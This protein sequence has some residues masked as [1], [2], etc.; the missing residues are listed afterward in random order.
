ME[1]SLVLL[2]PSVTKKYSEI[3]TSLK[4]HGFAI[5]DVCPERVNYQSQRFRLTHEQ[6]TDFF[7]DRI[8]E[9]QFDEILEEVCGGDVI[10]LIVAKMDV[11]KE[12]GELLRGIESLR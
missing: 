12:L 7:Q 11:Y 6:A 3:S 10:S 5:K 2:K 8:D 9:S 4:Q 1:H